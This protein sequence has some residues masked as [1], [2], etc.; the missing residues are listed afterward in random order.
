MNETTPMS[1]PDTVDYYVG[2]LC[3]VMDDVWDEVCALVPF[4]NSDKQFQLEDGREFFMLTTA[5]GDGSYQDQ[6]GRS[7]GVD[8]GTIGAIR[9]SDIRDETA[10]VND[11]VTRRLAQV[12]PVV[13]HL[14]DYEVFEEDGLLT[15]GPVT[16]D[17]AGAWED[18]DDDDYEGDED[19]A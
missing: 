15:F 7:Y 5:Y 11:L 19:D 2:D 10:N 9:L 8:S 17:T 16:I 1:T 6:Q 12:I 4:N 3:Y 14:E 13:S 18:D